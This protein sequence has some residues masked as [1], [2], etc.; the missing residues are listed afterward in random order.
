MP[1][2]GSSWGEEEVRKSLMKQLVTEFTPVKAGVIIEQE[3]FELGWPGIDLLDQSLV[4]LQT[5]DQLL[6]PGQVVRVVG[7][8][9]VDEALLPSGGEILFVGLIPVIH[10]STNQS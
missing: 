2:L 4:A 1:V 8:L 5:D 9:Q 10:L 6:Q 3:L 7:L